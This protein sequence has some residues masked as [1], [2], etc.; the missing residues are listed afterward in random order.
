MIDVD[1]I[2][3]GAGIAGL[4]ASRL[5]R[6]DGFACLILEASDRVGGRILGSEV[7]AEA[8]LGAEFIHGH[9]PSVS[10]LLRKADL[11]L[12][13]YPMD[14]ARGRVFKHKG[15]VF[16]QDSA[17][18]NRVEEIYSK[19]HTYKGT[20]DISVYQYAKDI[21][22][23]Q[24][25]HFFFAAARIERL[26]AASVH[27]LSAV[28]LRQSLRNSGD[29]DENARIAGGFGRL[30]QWLTSDATIILGKKVMALK[31]GSEN[32]IVACEDGARY[33]AKHV[34]VTIPIDLVG[35]MIRDG[36]ICVPPAFSEGIKSLRMGAAV[37]IL[38]HFKRSRWPRFSA[39]ATDG[40]VQVW[41]NQSH[42]DSLGQTLVGFTAGPGTEEVK[43]LGK[44]DLISQAKLDI[45]ALGAE[46]Y[47]EDVID[48]EVAFWDTFGHRAYSYVPHGALNG[49]EKLIEFES[50]RL[51]FAGEAYSV[52]G[53]AGTIGGAIES[54]SKVTNLVRG[55][56]LRS[57]EAAFE[58]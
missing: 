41:W 2:I 18:A 52:P 23:D 17:F 55:I 53:P 42:K 21:F 3:V 11:D 50:Q 33:L 10:D 25:E 15:K 13:P 27:E 37:K 34:I 20:E 38:I 51:S 54:A 16:W 12:D 29:S 8:Q 57:R 24:D 56:L 46:F 26:E 4:T 9:H 19:L 7:F 44:K 39:Y 32:V 30:L 1:V 5:L 48:V 58:R 6:A 49:R 40:A 47:E 43:M 31:C 36:G 45:Q 22:V 14:G 35:A 28:A